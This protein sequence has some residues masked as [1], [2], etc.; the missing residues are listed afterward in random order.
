MKLDTV[1]VKVASRCNINCNYCYVYNMGDS[2][3]AAMP[4][5]ISLE[6]IDA[7]AKSLQD[8]SA[9]RD[10]QFSVVL[11][12][13]EPLLLGPKKL[14]QVLQRLRTKLA[15]EYP[16]AIQTNGILLTNEVLDICSEMRTT[17]S[18]S[19][20]GPRHIHDEDR[21]THS[22]R[23]TFDQVCAVSICFASIAK[24][25]FSTRDCSLSSIQLPIQ[26]KFTIS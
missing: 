19:I 24:Q 18:I 10:D 14:K 20:D 8:F 23:G 4:T 22:G 3:W 17:I 13:G 6:T 15:E 25:I 16:L 12:G 2:G 7:V 1:L 26:K 11:H 21:I 5:Q 9:A